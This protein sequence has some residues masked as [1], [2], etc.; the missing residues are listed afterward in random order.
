MN[1]KKEYIII[2]KKGFS[3][4]ILHSQVALDYT[5]LKWNDSSDNSDIIF[6]VLVNIFVL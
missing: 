5:W 6:C 1:K 3:L 4:R 2:R